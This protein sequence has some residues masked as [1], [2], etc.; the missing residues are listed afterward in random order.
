MK[1]KLKYLGKDKHE[2]SVYEDEQG[3]IYK[4]T[5]PREYNTDYIS[6]IC[7]SYNNEFDGEP[8]TPIMYIFEELTNRDVIFND[9]RVNW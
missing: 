7:T 8:D 3:N 6:Q 5:D 9:K 1:L 4:D 2:R